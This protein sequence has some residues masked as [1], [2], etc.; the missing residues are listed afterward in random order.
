MTN[1]LVELE[2]ALA[3]IR[4]TSEP[5]DERLEELKQQYETV[6]T[7]LEAEFLGALISGNWNEFD[8]FVND[9]K[10]QCSLTP[11]ITEAVD[12]DPAS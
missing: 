2:S 9:F 1:P 5:L 8:Q 10:T 12:D 6:L 7:L 4:F 3:H 11:T